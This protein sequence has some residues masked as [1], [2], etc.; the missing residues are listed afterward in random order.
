M[1]ASAWSA[2]LAPPALSKSASC[3][4]CLGVFLMPPF[5]WSPVHCL[6]SPQPRSVRGVWRSCSI[7][8]RFFYPPPLPRSFSFSAL[9]S[10]FSARRSPWG[11]TRL[12][13]L[14]HLT[15]IGTCC[16]SKKSSELYNCR[17]R[18]IRDKPLQRRR[19]GSSPH[20]P[21]DK[22]FSYDRVE[23]PSFHNINSMRSLPGVTYPVAVY[24]SRRRDML[25]VITVDDL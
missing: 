23:V 15:T 16:W 1:T 4:C 7:A 22:R 24:L 17:E 6:E 10:S 9:R 19:F 25:R 11:S 8:S 5:F 2:D 21:C 20:A 12:F 3:S 14:I 18:R 13:R